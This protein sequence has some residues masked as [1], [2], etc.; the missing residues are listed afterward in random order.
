[1]GFEQTLTNAVIIDVF[2]ANIRFNILIFL[3]NYL[4]KE[5]LFLNDCFYIVQRWDIIFNLG[6]GEY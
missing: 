1:M 2:K 6:K 3:N 4:E 5:Q